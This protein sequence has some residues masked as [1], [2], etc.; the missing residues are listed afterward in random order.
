MHFSFFRPGYNPNE[1]PTTPEKM[2]YATP[3]DRVNMHPIYPLTYR[4]LLLVTK[5]I[6]SSFRYFHFELLLTY[7]NII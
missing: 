2:K 1:R 6:Y 4:K 5:I 7:Q 3:P